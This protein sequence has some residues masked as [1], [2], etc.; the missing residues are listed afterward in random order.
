MKDE[1]A[2]IEREVCDSS[3]TLRSICEAGTCRQTGNAAGGTDSPVILC[4][5]GQADQ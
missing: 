1:S 2:M 3:R 5:E 4:D